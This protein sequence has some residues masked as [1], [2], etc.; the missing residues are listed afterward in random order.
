MMIFSPI[1][2]YGQASD[3]HVHICM[4]S[5]VFIQFDDITCSVPRVGRVPTKTHR[6][7]VVV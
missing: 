4:W 7:F 5:N 3:A 1:G 6:S 2:S